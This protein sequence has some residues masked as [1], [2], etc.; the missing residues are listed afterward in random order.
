MDRAERI[1]SERGAKKKWSEEKIQRRA[2]LRRGVKDV[3]VTV[4]KGVFTGGVVLLR[5]AIASMIKK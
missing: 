1:A 4:V 3:V 2:A 5:N